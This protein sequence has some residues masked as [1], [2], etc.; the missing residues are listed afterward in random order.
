MTLMVFAAKPLE[1]GR[2]THGFFARDG[3][4]STGIYEGLNC[5]QG[6]RDTP[7]HVAE[8]R[9]RVAQHFGTTPD[10]LCTLYQV[11][12]PDVVMVH[13]P[14]SATIKA[15]AMV[16][17]HPGLVLGI[18][19][20]DCAPVLFADEQAGVIGAAHAGWKGAHGG[21]L[22]H[23]VQA[24]L[25]A[26]A[27][28]SRI[29]AAVGPC[30]AQASYEVGPDFIDTLKKQDPTNAQFFAPN[31]KRGHGQFNLEG[32]VVKQLRATGLQHITPLAMDTYSNEPQFFSFRRTTHRGELDYG[33]QISCI[34]LRERRGQ[35]G[36]AFLGQERRTR[37]I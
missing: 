19:T 12:S 36:S 27:V 18:L 31:T 35:G 30:I 1:G 14:T 28:R 23:T 37:P 20:A 15:D 17:T 32:Y 6:S 3:G 34:M 10:K 2:V 13:E 9:A 26:G 29:I 5:G 24:M 25:K 16:T 4:V 11:H 33:R 21:V 7:E 8:N 22:E